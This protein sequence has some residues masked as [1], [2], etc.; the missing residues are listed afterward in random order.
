MSWNYL[1]SY[2]KS[3]SFLFANKQKGFGLIEMMVSIGILSI[4]MGVVFVRQDSHNSSLLLRNQAYEIAFRLREVQFSA[5]SAQGDLDNFRSVLGI[6]FDT[7]GVN[8]GVYK[9]FK[10]SNSDGFYVEAEDEEFGVQGVLDKRFEISEIR[11]GATTPGAVSVIFVRPNFDARFFEGSGAGNE[12]HD[13]SVFIDIIEKNTTNTK[14]VEVTA[15][16]QIGVI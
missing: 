9:I 7:A 13:G 2:K 15:T 11:S 12:L 8:N 16:G 1:P 4:V 10:D 14:T 5:V 3:Q 6:H